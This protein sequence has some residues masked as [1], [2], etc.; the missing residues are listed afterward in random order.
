[1]QRITP[2]EFEQTL[3]RACTPM[4]RYREDMPLAEWQASARKKLAALLGGPYGVCDAAVNIEYKR[5][6]ALCN[7]IRFTYQSEPGYTV[8]AHLLLPKGATKPLPVVICLQGHSKG[9][10]ISLGRPQYDGD[11]EMIRGDRDFAVQAVRR[12]FA[13]LAIEQRNFGECGGTEKGPG[14]FRAAMN[15]LLLGRTVIGERVWDI[16]RAVDVL[17]DTFPQIDKERI[18]CMGQSAGGTATFYAACM[19]E[20]IK[21]AMPSGA[22]CSF[23]SSIMAIEHCSCNYIPQMRLYFD[24][25]DL[26]MLIA[27][28]PLVVVTG[29]EDDIFPL[30]GVKEAVSRISAAYRADGC[31]DCLRL[32]IGDGGHRFYAEKAWRAFSGFVQER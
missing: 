20:R 25:G 26:G 28:R 24:M 6:E 17:C 16:C 29:R 18:Y 10:H 15:A 21:A 19:D 13:A 23:D 7:E 4:M 11:A 1:M 12:G 9:M 27:P 2:Y 32:V 31:P 5:E 30:D 8:P 3:S 14:C 22:V